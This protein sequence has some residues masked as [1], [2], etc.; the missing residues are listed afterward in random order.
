M[1]LSKRLLLVLF[2]VALLPA[3]TSAQTDESLRAA[4][5]ADLMSDPRS[6]EMSPTEIDAMVEA[7]AAQAEEEGVAADYLDSQN[8]FEA[9]PAPVFEE[10][11]T[12]NTLSIAIAALLLVLAA[13]A[14]FLIW[15]RHGRKTRTNA[16]MAA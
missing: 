11:I 16:E 8:T 5:R 3:F 10:E 15:Q 4:I 14:G 9:A 12:L 13:V 7:L 6:A 1:T 2:A